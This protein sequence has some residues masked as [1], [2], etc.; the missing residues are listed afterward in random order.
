MKTSSRPVEL[1]GLTAAIAQ[2][3]VVQLSGRDTQCPVL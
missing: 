2:P 3:D 1:L